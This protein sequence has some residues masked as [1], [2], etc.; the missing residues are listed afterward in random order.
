MDLLLS[1]LLTC[2]RCGPDHGL[3][4]LPDVV[5]DR[6][7]ESGVLGCPNCRERF[8]I[9]GGV[10]ELVV[11]GEVASPRRGEAA[12][13]PTGGGGGVGG[14]A[15]EG[16]AAR[17]GGLLGLAGATGMVLVAGP[18]SS[19]VGEL[20]RLV[21][22]LV[23]VVVEAVAGGRGWGGGPGVGA[24]P[25]SVIRAGRTL[26]FRTGSVRGVA[27]TGASVA[28]AAEGLRVLA[29]AARLLLEPAGGAVR[30]AVESAGGVVVLA[31]GETLVVS[32]AV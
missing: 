19:G 14:L 26:P 11:P 25:P 16:W 20:G 32:R 23:L 27:L 5:H 7:V 30:S 31:D 18:A 28:L 29:P 4:L 12:G 1:D 2:P 8:A 6:R 15:A 9:A 13:D 21:E 22:G 10:A 17:L 3:V 24:V